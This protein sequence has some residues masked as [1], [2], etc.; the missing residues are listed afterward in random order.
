M[1]DVFHQTSKI[2]PVGDV[3]ENQ[4][5]VYLKGDVETHDPHEATKRVP[6]VEVRMFSLD[7][8]GNLVAP[9]HAK[10]IRI[11]E[12]G[13]DMRPIRSTTMYRDK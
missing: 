1:V 8:A 13:P 6:I 4:R 2:T 5:F 12:L 3:P 10:T 11:Q 9:D 7:E